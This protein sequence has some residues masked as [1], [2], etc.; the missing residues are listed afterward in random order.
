MSLNI[1]NNKAVCHSALYTKFNCCR[2]KKKFRVFKYHPNDHHSTAK[3]VAH[4]NRPA[5][6]SKKKIKEWKRHNNKGQKVYVCALD[7]VIA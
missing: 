7:G 6:C 2:R 5:V 1:S 3:T 4:T